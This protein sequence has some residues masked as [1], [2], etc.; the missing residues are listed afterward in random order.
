M[1]PPCIKS[2]KCHD[3]CA[4]VACQFVNHS[5]KPYDRL[6]LTAAGDKCCKLWTITG[7]LVGLFGQHSRWNLRSEKTFAFFNIIRV[8]E[9]E[10]Q[11]A[12]K[13]EAQKSKQTDKGSRSAASSLPLL[14]NSKFDVRLE[15]QLQFG[16]NFIDLDFSFIGYRQLKER[17]RQ[18]RHLITYR[19]SSISNRIWLR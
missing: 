1:P 14:S 18:S 4:I 5:I 10:N 3:N 9:E 2:W 15:K 16:N 6:L 13:E 12:M 7:K 11:R 8:I 17:T 19:Q